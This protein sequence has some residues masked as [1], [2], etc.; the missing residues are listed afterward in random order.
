MDIMK[1]FAASGIVPVVVLENAEDAVPCER[2][3][4]CHAIRP[5]RKTSGA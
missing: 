4:H 5:G 2:N 1:Q 3:Q